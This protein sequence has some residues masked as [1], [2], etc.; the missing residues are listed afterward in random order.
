MTRWAR[1]RIREGGRTDQAGPSGPRLGV[2]PTDFFGTSKREHTRI[3]REA[4]DAA[5]LVTNATPAQARLLQ[6]LA[7][8]YPS[9]GVCFPFVATL[10]RFLA[11]TASLDEAAGAALDEAAVA[12]L[13]R[14]AA[15]GTEEPLD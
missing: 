4:A 7:A 14:E 13:W 11:A 12:R 3:T 9:N 5:A 15:E 1:I 6:R 10:E 2:T 8:A